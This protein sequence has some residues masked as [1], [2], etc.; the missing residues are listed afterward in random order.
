[1]SFV[2]S[3]SPV[4][5]LPPSSPSPVA[6]SSPH[7]TQLPIRSIPGSYGWPVLGPISDRLDYFWFQKPETFFRKRMER[8]KSSVFR[9][10]VPPS[11]PF[12][13][14]VNPNVVALL[15]CKSFSHLFDME[16]VEKKDVLI[17]DFRPSVAFT[18]NIRVGVYQDISEPQHSK[19]QL[20]FLLKLFPFHKFCF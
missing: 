11:F 17:G 9:T 16:L 4:M 20:I 14:N 18:G 7:S 1:M 6:P 12:F 10:N 3:M 13:R 2:M 8:Y 5:S 19:V 15:D